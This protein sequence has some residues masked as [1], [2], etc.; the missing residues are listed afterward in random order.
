MIA[1]SC[2]SGTKGGDSVFHCDA[3]NPKLV[4]GV[5]RPGVAVNG[6]PVQVRWAAGKYHP[7]VPDKLLWS[8]RSGLCVCELAI[9]GHSNHPQALHLVTI[10]L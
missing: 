2:F 6:S 1:S 5:E 10:T 9:L 7:A 8:H 4:K 3:N